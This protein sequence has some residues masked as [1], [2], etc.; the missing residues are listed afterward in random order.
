MAKEKIM[1]DNF[2]VIVGVLAFLIAS[3][4]SIRFAKKGGIKSYEDVFYLTFNSVSTGI[5]AGIVVWLG[6]VFPVF[7]LILLSALILA[8]I[9]IIVG[10]KSV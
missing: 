6:T 1:L 9:L 2:Y 8:L 3:I 7:I 4:L 10:G 5:V